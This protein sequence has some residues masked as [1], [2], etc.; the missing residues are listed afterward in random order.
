MIWVALTWDAAEVPAQNRDVAK[1]RD[2]AQN[3]DSADRPNILII[4][5]DNLGYGDLPSYR[6][7][8]PIKTPQLDRLAKQGARLTQFYTASSTCTVSRACFL[9]GRVAGRHG[10]INQLPGIKGNYGVGLNPD[11]ILISQ[12]MKRGGY[13][14]G[15]F[16]KWNIGFAP[17]SRPTERGFD[18]FVGHASGNID[19]YH[20]RYNGKHDLFRG[21]EEFHADGQYSSD[22]FA[23]AAIDFI[24]RKS[25]SETPWFCY[26]PFNA[27]HFPNKKNK[28]PGQASVWQ[29]PDWAF[30]QYGWS[31]DQADPGKRYAAVVT[32]MDRSL[33]RVLESLDR[34][35]VADNTFVFFYS[36]NGAFRLGR[37]GIDVG[38]NTPLRGGGITCWEGGIRVAAMV[39]WPGRVRRG[40]V[41]ETPLWTPDLMIACARLADIGLPEDRVLDGRDPLPA[42]RGLGQAEDLDRSFFFRFRTHAAL[43]RGDWKIVREKPNEP[44]MLFNLRD[45]VS[46]R[47]DRAAEKPKTVAELRDE[48]AR[49][50]ESVS[51]DG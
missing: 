44:W 39:R 51:T 40:A 28:L 42:I 30:E 4:T 11:E 36:D 49:W 37:K 12:L 26:L 24:S 8:S 2:S 38:D 21:V 34:A 46:E 23:D 22:L 19:Y 47:H 20:H 31:P 33:G 15:C 18:E 29:A 17:G 16:G 45:D 48:F 41:I 1:D 32:A 6:P 35:G 25:A 3:R 13:A 50:E 7:E 5:A 10:L 9:T 14:T 43:R 27:P